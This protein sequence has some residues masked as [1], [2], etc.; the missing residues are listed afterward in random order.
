MSETE[1]Q[2]FQSGP[3]DH[4]DA[5]ANDLA[6]QA[7]VAP[8]SD[9]QFAAGAAAPTSTGET[10][11]EATA[12]SADEALTD[13]SAFE[14]Q[15]EDSDLANALE[16]IADL[17][18][19]LARAH[20]DLY[21]LNQE[22]SNYV[23]RAKEAASGHRESGQSEVIEALISV[24]DDIDAARTHGE[25]ED[26]PF[27]AIATKL[28]SV[29]AS[30]FN[31]ERYGATGEEFDPAQHE[32]LLAN[33]NPEVQVATIAQILQPGYRRD[34]KILRAAKVMVDNPE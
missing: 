31:L 28:E 13:M 29:L 20:A 23:R 12:Q 17:E 25:L 9:E 2:G 3:Q 15:V 14:E 6:S 24:L 34:E 7:Q 1:N 33:V 22:Y 32:A 26:G 5:E 4:S 19:Q 16:K 27:A 21:N 11:G 10:A 30:R 18:D 8:S